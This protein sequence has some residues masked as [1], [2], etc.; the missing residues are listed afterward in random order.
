VA[1]QADYEA[2]LRAASPDFQST[3]GYEAAAPGEANMTMAT[4]YVA[5]THGCLSMTLEQ[6]FKDNADAPLAELGWSPER[7]RRLGWANLD[8][9]LAVAERLR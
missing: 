8:A 6:P 4:N 1:L 3:H 9:L 7:A 2:A 5:E